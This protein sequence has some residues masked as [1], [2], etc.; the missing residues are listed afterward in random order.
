MNEVEFYKMQ[1][2]ITGLKKM[3][4]R[5]MYFNAILAIILGIIVFVCY[6]EICQSLYTIDCINEYKLRQILGK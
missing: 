2:D 3:L 1:Q 5:S 6:Q 4:K